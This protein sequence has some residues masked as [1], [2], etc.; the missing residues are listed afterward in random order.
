MSCLFEA[1][2]GLSALADKE[3]GRKLSQMTMD[4]R[5]SAVVFM[6]LVCG[7]PAAL[8]AQFMIEG[9]PVQI[10]GFASQGFTYSNDNNYL[11][12]QTSDGS[13]NFTDG[14]VNISAPI[15][16]KLH[17]GAQMYIRNIGTLGQ[18]HPDL[19]WAVV[20]Y[21]LKNWFCPR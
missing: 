14:G 20:E 1:S 21:N 16:D 3:C 4:T 7:V 5:K 12:M 8:H 9:R 10:H 11:T 13:F 19:D 15:T 18:W 6:T 2:K 17:V